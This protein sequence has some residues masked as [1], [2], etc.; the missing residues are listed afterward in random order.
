[1][2]E[3]R[4]PLLRGKITAVE[5]YQRNAGAPVSALDTS[6]L[7]VKEHQESLL[8]QLAE[9]SQQ[10]RARDRAQRD[11]L[12]T[13]EII[14]IHPGPRMELMAEQLDNTKADS[15]MVGVFADTGVVLLDVASA[16]L[17]YLRDKIDAFADDSK[18]SRKRRPDGTTTSSRAHER[19][20]APIQSIGLAGFDDVASSP[21][22]ED[23]LS[24]DHPHWLEIACRGGYRNP[25]ADE[26]NSR[27]QICRQL[28]LMDLLD[29]ELPEFR[30]PEQIYFFTRL[31]RAQLYRLLQATDCI[32]EVAL[33]PRPLRDLLLLEDDAELDLKDFALSLPPA[34][35]PSVVLLDTGISTDHPMLK[36]AILSATFATPKITSAEDTYGHGTKMAGISLYRDL[37]AAI[38]RRS[39]QA[40]HWLQSSRLLIKPGQGLGA[41]AHHEIWPVLTEKAVRAAEEADPVSRERVFVLA[42]TRTMQEPPL[43]GL[44]PTLWSHAI[45]KLSFGEGSSRL[46]IVSAGN[47]RDSQWLTL[48]QDH[49]QLQLS[50][51][52]HQPAQAANA[53]TVGAFTTRVELPMS[54]NYE[55]ARVVAVTPGGISPF[56]STGLVGNE[57][58]IKPD[59]VLEGG[60]LAV[61]QALHDADVPTL[62]ALTTSHRHTAG[63]PLGMLAMTSEASAR[64]AHLAARIWLLEPRLRPETV[65]G[66]IVH[67]ASWTSAM[68]EHF[69]GVDD[70]LLACGYGVP[71]EVLATGCAQGIAT[72]LIED[73]I[74]NSVVEE[75]PKKKK[76]KR[77]ATKSTELKARR[78]LKIFR[79]PV[80]HELL[81]DSDPDV[82]LRVTL[83]YFAEPRKF[84][85]STSHG[86]D[87]KWDMQGPQE[88][89]REFLQRINM[90]QRPK[91]SS[92]ELTKGKKRKSFKWDIGIRRRSR[93]TV[94]S[95]RWS[96]KMSS[97]SGDKLIAIVPVN[98]WWDQRQGLK[99]QEMR[100]SLIVSVLGPGVY[101]AIKPRVE[102]QALAPIEV[103]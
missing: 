63:R 14:A 62:N 74:P 25:P 100:F 28:H 58:S 36:E 99:E 15:R 93:G 44:M 79:L 95:D 2:A 66:L 90:F 87:L 84:G 91:S 12:A 35:A 83:S 1:M 56:T 49:P 47:A 40:S 50:E 97:L 60:N 8:R 9:I 92:G 76:P 55:E 98:G 29:K 81:G 16:D 26:Q 51:K 39:W 69:D 18:I 38:E 89:E 78:K 22:R 53:L 27:A 59:V 46:M 71:D 67:S 72:I 52:I 54:R 19:A 88:S 61:S 30:G 5:T 37:G 20:I 31:D 102:A 24:L 7:D 17:Q 23:A 48:A 4:F 3:D 43:E 21:L 103:Q 96:G 70:R 75:E 42:V 41:D 82:E 32:Y 94:Q 11:E 6:S 68:T 10:V 73:S 57:W 80:P 13:R 33:A 101:S 45:D 85:P 77:A 34:D 64:A 86:L 65:R